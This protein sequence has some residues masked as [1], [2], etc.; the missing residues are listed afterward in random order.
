MTRPASGLDC[1]LYV[2]NFLDSDLTCES[3]S[4]A[5]RPVPKENYLATSEEKWDNSKRFKD[6]GLEAEA[7]A[8]FYVPHSLDRENVFM[9]HIVSTFCVAHSLFRFWMRSRLARPP[10]SKGQCRGRQQRT[11][12]SPDRAERLFHRKCVRYCRR[13]NFENWVYV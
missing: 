5:R 8:V 2:A 1:V 11:S 6:F 9:Y 7:L 10:T 12:A 13:S 4:A 3:P